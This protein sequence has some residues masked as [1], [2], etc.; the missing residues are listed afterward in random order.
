MPRAHMCTGT[1]AGNEGKDHSDQ[2]LF[3]VMQKQN[4]SALKRATPIDPDY[5]QKI[6]ACPFLFY[7]L[8]KSLHAPVSSRVYP[9]AHL[10]GDMITIHSICVCKQ[11][12]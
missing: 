10:P 11:I 12:E 8:E 4:E 9:H 3:W 6:C 5:I 2:Y 1:R 7:Y